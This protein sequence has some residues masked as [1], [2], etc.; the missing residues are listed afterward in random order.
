LEKRE[1]MEKSQALVLQRDENAREAVRQIIASKECYIYVSR[2]DRTDL[3][4]QCW[5][6]LEAKGAAFMLLLGTYGCVVT[7]QKSKCTF[8][9]FV[10]CLPGNSET[11]P[12]MV[13]DHEK[14]PER[15]IVYAQ[16]FDVVAFT[17]WV[18]GIPLAPLPVDKNGKPR[19]M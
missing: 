16:S 15:D 18:E 10:E 7:A 19:L 9:D 12:L 6:G 11:K 3:A 13:A 1:A 17:A 4:L 8:A 5:R 2:V 14:H